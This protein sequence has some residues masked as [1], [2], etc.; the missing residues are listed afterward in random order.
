MAQE[1]VERRQYSRVYLKAYGY[2]IDCEVICVNRHV[3]KASLIDVSRGGAR[4]MLT[5]VDN[6]FGIGD[7]L[8]FSLPARG[9]EDLQGVESVVRWK[10]NRE[11]GLEFVSP[12][13]TGVSELQEL[14]K[15]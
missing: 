6:R 11:L 14:I 2:N 4:L 9:G 7:T 8:H 13:S 12:L 10:N 3:R 15:P 5:Q 1:F